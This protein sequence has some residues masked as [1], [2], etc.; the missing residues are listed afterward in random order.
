MRA[1]DTMQPVNALGRAG[2]WALAVT[3]GLILSAPN[4]VR[5]D[6]T[7]AITNGSG[8][9]AYIQENGGD[10]N[11]GTYTVLECNNNPGYRRKSYL[12]F[13]LAAATSTFHTATLKLLLNNHNNS[14]NAT[15]EVYGL[16]D[17]DAGEGWGETTITWNNAPQNDTDGDAFIA[18]GVTN[19]GTFVVGSADPNGTEYTFT[20]IALTQ[21]LQAD[22]DGQATLMLRS[23]NGGAAPHVQ[24]ASKQND[25]YAPPRLELLDDAIVDTGSGTGADALIF[26]F[27]PDSN[28]GPLSQ[29]QCNRNTDP[30]KRKSYVRFDLSTAPD[31]IG[32]ATLKLVLDDGNNTADATIDV[33]GLND[34][35]AGE[36]WGETAITWNN[37][38]QN[39]T[40]NNDFL[41]GTTHL[42]SFDVATTD[43][44]G[45]VYAFR[46]VALA[47]FLNAD[48]DGRAT[49]MLRSAN[50]GTAPWVA[51]ASKENSA[52]AA[53]TLEM[54]TTAIV[55][56]GEGEGADAFIQQNA[57]DANYGGN[58]RFECN[59][60]TGGPGFRRKS[61]LRFD[62][63]NK[64]DLIG[65]AALKLVTVDCNNGAASLIDVY[66]L[67]D[68]DAG[69][70]WGETTIT[71]NNAPQNDTDD[72]AF[73]AGATHLGTLQ[74]AATAPDGTEYAF[75]NATLVTFLSADT[76]D[77]AT[78]LL[79]NQTG[80]TAP[81][82]AFA[83]KENATYAPP[84]LE[85]APGIPPPRGTVI[86]IK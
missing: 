20:S 7:I 11:Y 35:D 34:G 15:I 73:L 30:Y 56:T 14:V 82:V 28:Y 61:Y 70:G 79:R 33:Y 54:K 72:D 69:E 63:A 16:K 26:Q 9:D 51:F 38:P 2:V 32:T 78:F 84:T 46:D 86:I 37:A 57:P 21:F 31:K 59:N 19:L 4:A 8:A 77:R 83:S 23:L 18:S 36:A 66:G 52:Y 5:G 44:D 65:R 43:A 24:F 25:S 75:T 50:G 53:P 47:R 58:N 10:N 71:W 42:G 29:L 45:T 60:N 85:M 48:T 40:N 22:T 41:G 39:N 13:D 81:Y 76:D 12:R 74:V 80:G 64:P 68:G 67:N 1:T 3:A 55:T 17:G 62:I 49:L 27:S 6:V